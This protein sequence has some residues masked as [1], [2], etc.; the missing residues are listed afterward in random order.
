M[1]QHLA[2][3]SKLHLFG[4]SFRA[5]DSKMREAV[6]FDS[7]GIRELLGKAKSHLPGFEAMVLSTCNRTEFYL[8]GRAVCLDAWHELLLA[9]RPSTRGVRWDKCPAPAP[10]EAGAGRYRLCGDQAYRH[11]IRVACGLE[12]AILGDAQILSQVRQAMAAAVQA[13]TAGAQLN[14]AFT[15]AVKTAKLA[16]AETDISVGS[17]GIA[18]AVTTK[19]QTEGCPQDAGILVVGA[20]KVARAV[21]EALQRAGYAHLSFCA[22]RWG[23]AEGI[24]RAFGA[25][26]L[27]WGSLDEALRADVVIV[28]TGAPEPVIRLNDTCPRRLLEG[29]QLVIDVGFP[30]QV[31]GDDPHVRVVSLE[32]LRDA[33]DLVARRAA[34]VPAVLRLIDVEVSSWRRWQSGLRL[35]ERLKALHQDAQALTDDLSRTLVDGA[36]DDARRLR[37]SLRRMLHD[38]TV[39]LRALFETTLPTSPNERCVC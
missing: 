11:L 33:D 34:S 28:A 36:P 19:L 16:R 26:T 39:E 21:G 30:R 13:G 4:V 35:E 38:H 25:Q 14:R 20:G 8:A 6:A 5:T 18:G 17:P 2:P 24:A 12:S 27:P 37:R 31:V 10:A 32:D 7:S 9:A 15:G 23:A 29:E 1:D 3:S 22:R